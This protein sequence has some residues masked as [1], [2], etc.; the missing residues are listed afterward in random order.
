METSRKKSFVSDR[1]ETTGQ[2]MGQA[3]GNS[4][5]RRI[6]RIVHDERGNARLDWWDA[7]A[8]YRRPVLEIESE[9][10]GLGIQ[11]APRTFD[12][13][14]CATPPE[15]KKTAAAGPRKDLR[16][17]SEWIKMMRELEERKS[18]GEEE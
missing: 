1:H 3:T 18:R 16:K 2:A 17:L 6:G 15:Q 8:D 12:P 14:A 11:K 10:Q 13:Y 4:E 9:S 7:P 5:R